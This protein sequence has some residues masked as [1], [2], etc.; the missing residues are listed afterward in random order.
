MA[1]D[2]DF[3]EASSDIIDAFGTEG[4][5]TRAQTGETHSTHV[6]I[7]VGVNVTSDD[8][9][10]STR[11]THATLTKPL[12]ECEQGD[13]IKADGRTYRVAYLL[14]DDGINVTLVLSSVSAHDLQ[15]TLDAAKILQT[16]IE[17]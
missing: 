8:G 10:T 9:F 7:D 11:Q 17:G 2:D 4:T 12:F 6:V 13:L 3:R 1:F 15:N 16:A 14:D 5:Y